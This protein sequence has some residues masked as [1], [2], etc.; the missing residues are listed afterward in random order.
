MAK[1]NFEDRLKRLEKRRKATDLTYHMFD[2]LEAGITS[3][4]EFSSLQNKRELWE[5][6]STKP[7]VRYSTGAMQAV[8]QR[9]TEIG[10]ETAKRI[11][12]QLKTRLPNHGLATEYKLQGSVP[13][14]IHIKGVSDVDLLVIHKNHY[15][16]EDCT[17]LL[18]SEDI[19]A[20]Q[21]LRN[22]SF[23]ELKQAYPAVRIDNSGGKCISLTGG[24]LPRD[25]DVVPS[26]WVETNEYKNKGFEYLRGINILDKNIPTTFLNLPFAHIYWIKLICQYLTEGSLRKSIRLCKTIKADLIDEGSNITLSSYDLASIMYHANR[27]NLKHSKNYSLGIVLETQRF[28]D[29]LYH[30]QNYAKSLNTPDGTRKIFDSTE[31][32]SSLIT[33]S[34]ALD[35]LVSDLCQDLGFSSKESL[36]FFPLSI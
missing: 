32:L 14:D 35:N 17:V 12:N 3:Y 15:R 2:S 8:D 11:E 26:H 23:Y 22:S 16:S 25:V 28:F 19:K 5:S 24:S 13:L 20:L 30:N 18:R 4:S 6:I 33:L 31:K 27:D 10:I 36:K 1:I 21:Q 7:S 9:Y 34:I 29:F